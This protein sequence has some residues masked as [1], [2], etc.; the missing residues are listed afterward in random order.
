VIAA[1]F[2]VKTY[3][4]RKRAYF[5]R[6]TNDHTID[7]LRELISVGL[8]RKRIQ[9]FYWL[10]IFDAIGLA[11]LTYSTAASRALGTVSTPTHSPMQ[12]VSID[13][14]ALARNPDLAAEINAQQAYLVQLKS[15]LAADEASF[16]ADADAAIAIQAPDWLGPDAYLPERR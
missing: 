10:E 8:V 12:R 5:I 16:R 4:D 13:P 6:G 11:Y 1:I 2:L 3:V 7:E 9:Y 14:V 15:D